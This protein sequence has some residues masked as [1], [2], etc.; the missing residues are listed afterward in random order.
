MNEAEYRN[1]LIENIEV[2]NELIIK[3][4]KKN[5]IIYILIICFFIVVLLLIFFIYST[6][7]K[8]DLRNN[9]YS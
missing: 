4:N 8:K 3:V 6:N 2:I 7:K 1:I 9:K 5:K